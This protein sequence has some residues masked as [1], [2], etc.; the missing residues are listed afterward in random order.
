M[1]FRQELEASTLAAQQT[2]ELKGMPAPT[3]AV[4][5]PFP[6]VFDAARSCVDAAIRRLRP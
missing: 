2:F 1:L 4:S 5:F 3:L 6:D